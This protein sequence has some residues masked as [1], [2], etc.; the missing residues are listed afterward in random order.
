MLVMPIGITLPKLKGK[1]PYNKDTY[2]KGV[3]SA[4]ED[5]LV[6]MLANFTA[7][8]TPL[9][10]ITGS[11]KEWQVTILTAAMLANEHLA[12]SMHAE[13][14]V[15]AAINYSNIIEERLGYYQQ[16]QVH[17]LERLIQ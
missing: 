1:L 5:K 12:A 8:G 7:D 15:D 2:V 14:M 9:S 10:A 17:N 16:N 3:M 6:E 4:K 13:E 11:K